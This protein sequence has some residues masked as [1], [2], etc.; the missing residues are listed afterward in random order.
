MCFPGLKK[1]YMQN[2]QQKKKLWSGETSKLCS[3]WQECLERTVMMLRVRN[4]YRIYNHV[5]I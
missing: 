5:Y 1:L 2:G 3:I 4:K